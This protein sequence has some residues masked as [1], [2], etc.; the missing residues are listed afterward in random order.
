[1]VAALSAAR[2]DAGEA[3]MLF[4]DL[5]NPTSNAIYQALGYRRVGDSISITF[6]A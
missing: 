1:M 6:S 2:L 5:A 4:T 3:C